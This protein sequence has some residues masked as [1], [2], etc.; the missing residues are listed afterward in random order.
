MI[1]RLQLW[2]WLVLA[3]P[4]LAIA[5]TLLLAAGWQL[6][7][8]GLT[9]IWAVFIL[10]LAGWRWLLGRWLQPVTA[11]ETVITATRQELE[12]PAPRDDP[13]EAAAACVQQVL[14]AAQ[15]DPPLWESPQTFWQRCQELLTAIAHLYYPE[16]KYPL[17]NIY[18]PEAYTLLRGTID[19]LD[20]W[21]QQLAPVLNQLTV[22]QA[23]QG[24]ELYQTLEPSAR[25]LWRLWN[26]A[27]W[28]L[29]PATAAARLLSQATNE[30]ASQ[31]L[32]VNLSQLL[33]VAL[34]QNLG[35]Q[36]IALYGRKTGQTLPPPP[37]APQKTQTLQ[38][39]LAQAEPAEAIAQQPAQ[40]LLVGRT[41]AGKSSTINTLFQADL[42]A[43]DVLPSTDELQSYQWQ[44]DQGTALTLWDTPGYEQAEGLE[45]RE[46]VLAFARQADLVL[47]VLPALDP[48]LQMDADFLRDL[49]QEVADLPA[50]AIVTQVDR[51]RPL[52][53]WE[54]PY[55]WTTGDRPKEQAIRA[56]VEYRA[57]ALG[58]LCE[59]VLPLVAADPE[60]GRPGWNRSQL[61][62]ALLG[63]IDPAKQ[64]RLAR[65]LRDREARAT[66]AAQIIDR[67]VFQMTTQQGLAAFLK[68]P[69]LQFISTLV[70]G[71]PD[72]ARLLA[73]QIPVEQ[74]PVVIGKLQMAYELHQVINA[75]TDRHFEFRE[76]WPLLLENPAAPEA[77]ARAFGQA[78]VEYWCQDWNPAQLRAR[79]QTYL[80]SS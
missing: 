23:Y 62:Q 64:L 27:Q 55:Y 6:Q 66:A 60:R 15:N 80:Q 57:T 41:G 49:R 36:A 24:W 1:K 12:G 75:A 17:L 39:I 52:R 26:W 59:Q 54:P 40:I 10:V 21:M 68:S 37:L 9:W 19:D 20:R 33:R 67:Y 50:I 22:G 4:P 76:L 71:S 8:W 43:V 48:A 73:T 72:L 7:A 45:A 79:V 25:R 5:A 44:D 30:Q 3:G 47:L 2:Q 69:V 70:T 53:E 35:Q 13:S 42:A 56:A 65:F 78:L 34:L 16:T 51:L 77:N 18:I 31:Q 58:D 74:L 14:T 61:S 38:A 46:Q 63:A 11:M 28:L 32:L 29:N